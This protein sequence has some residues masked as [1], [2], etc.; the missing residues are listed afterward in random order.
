M[1]QCSPAILVSPKMCCVTQKDLIGGGL[2]L[3]SPPISSFCIV[4]RIFG[5]AKM[6]W[7]ALVYSSV[8]WLLYREMNTSPF[9]TGVSLREHQWKAK[10]RSKEIVITGEC[11]SAHQPF[12]FHQRCVADLIGGGQ[13][14]TIVRVWINSPPISSFCI[15]KRIFGEAKMHWWALVY[16]SVLW[17]LRH[18]GEQDNN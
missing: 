15:A 9:F 11:A 14:H 17:L 1:R 16:S 18:E 3:N 6:H 12:L 10:S 13:I 7:W 5:E 4:K 2:I 8:L